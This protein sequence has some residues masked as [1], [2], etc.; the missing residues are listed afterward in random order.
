MT[1]I[2]RD[3]GGYVSVQLSD[4]ENGESID[5]CDGF[6]YFTGADAKTDYKIPLENV[7]RIVR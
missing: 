7:V 6:A 2:Y 5:F 1:I 4:R 3:T